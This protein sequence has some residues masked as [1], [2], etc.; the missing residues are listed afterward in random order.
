MAS[1]EYLNVVGELVRDYQ[2][3]PETLEFMHELDLVTVSGP[4]GS[5]KNTVMEAT[6]LEVIKG[7]T[8]RP[9]R[10]PE[11]NDYHYIE[12]P[13]EEERLLDDLHHGNLVQVATHP[14]TGDF[15]GG[16]R[17]DY[18]LK[19]TGLLDVMPRYYYELRDEDHFASLR[20]T[21][22]IPPDYVTWQTRFLGRGKISPKEYIKRMHEATDSLAI[23]VPD[24]SFYY[25]INDVTELAA[26]ALH[27]FAL[28]NVVNM[29]GDMVA[30]TAAAKIQEELRGQPTLTVARARMRIE[31]FQHAG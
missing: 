21:S 15:Y 13:E 5:G 7:R 8:T 30:R 2:R 10:S 26:N 14:G 9:R 31:D 23:T 1:T 4:A 29:Y 3:S 24:H 19:G 20:A 6:G 25:I 17:T 27:L 22:L 28:N 12:E 16:D 18:A 11:D